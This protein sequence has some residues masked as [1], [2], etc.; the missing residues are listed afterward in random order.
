MMDATK[1]IQWDSIQVRGTRN[2]V[3][4]TVC[5]VCSPERKKKTDPCLYVNFD[6][7]VAKCFNCERLSFRDDEP[8][9]TEKRYELPPQQWRNF[10]QLSDRLVQW[11]FKER[12][13]TQTT[14]NHFEISEEVVFQP[15]KQK[16]M[17]SITFNYFEGGVLVNK[18]FRSATK[19]FTQ[20]KGGKPIFYNINSAI[21][22]EKVYIVE[23]EFDVL[24]MYEAGIKNCIS[25]PSGAND[26]DDY[27]ENSKAYLSDVKQFVIAVDNDEKGLAIREKIA[28]RLG[29]YRCSY[30]DWAGKDAN[31]DLKAGVIQDSLRKEKKF[32]VS[33]TFTAEDFQNEIFDLYEKGL[34][35]TMG[36]KKR[37]F[38]NLSDV[39][40][41][42]NGQLTVVTGIPS[43]GKSTFVDWYVLNL[44]DEHEVKVSI[45]SPEHSPMPLYF[46]NFMQK[47]IGKPF[48]GTVQGVEKMNKEDMQ[49][50]VDWSKNRLYLTGGGQ[51]EVMDWEWLFDKFK[52]QIFTFGINV[53][54]VDAWNK[55]QMPKG[56]EGKDGIDKILTRL[57]AFC[58][59]NNV[60]LFLVAHPTK[61]QKKKETGEYEV[62]KLYD[63]SGSS[64]FSNQ[65]HNGFSIYRNFAKANQEDSTDFFNLKTKFQ[66]Q[67]T[68]GGHVRFKYHIPTA[69]YY[70]ENCAPYH[71]DLTQKGEK[72]NIDYNP[73]AYIE[74]TNL[75]QYK[76]EE[77][78]YTPVED[79]PF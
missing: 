69:R 29:K 51:G 32:P 63:V 42:M 54:V 46:S 49:R 50:F 37:C 10:T 12:G 64:D 55:V 34:P 20:V 28:H 52:E 56:F 1:F 27:W 62:P 23:G 41:T 71:L 18:K 24:A 26:N 5:P 60:Q 2:G 73:N 36:L 4:K 7:G 61:M 6:T 25:L 21:G 67:G 68:I 58:L 72:V 38:G 45:F 8:R 15:A 31:D 74:P 79:C 77:F 66:F 75:N 30:I 44:I 22:A 76:N 19:D 40:S 59:Q 33:G 13:I 39:F 53:F 57:T 11:I 47:A 14:L 17:N 35:E 48:F 65:A 16:N 43:H 9:Q 70:E 78:D 3:K